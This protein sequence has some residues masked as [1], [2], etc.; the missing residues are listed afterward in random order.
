MKLE[1]LGNGFAKLKCVDGS[2][3]YFFESKKIPKEILDTMDNPDIPTEA[4]AFTCSM[5]STKGVI[6]A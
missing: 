2:S 1:K 3:M 5:V 4:D 6:S